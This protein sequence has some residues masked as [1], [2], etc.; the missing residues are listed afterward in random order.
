MTK[1]ELFDTVELLVDLPEQGI[2]QGAVGAIVHC[3][4]DNNYEVEFTNEDGETLA[5]CMLS[6]AQFIVVWR[7]RTRMWVPV[8]ERIAALVAHLPEEA[9]QEVLDFARFL[10][11]RRQQPLAVQK[12]MTKETAG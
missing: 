9:E 6:P 2:Q 8:A 11:T 1:P 3:Y 12:A 7:A 4:P 10:H 5:L